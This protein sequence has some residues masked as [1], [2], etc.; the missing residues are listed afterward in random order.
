VNALLEIPKPARTLIVLSA[1]NP[2]LKKSSQNERF[3]LINRRKKIHYLS[4][5]FS[6]IP[7]NHYQQIVQG[8]NYYRGYPVC[9]MQREQVKPFA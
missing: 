8:E 3:F 1:A 4:K 2:V 5:S 6:T 9:S 7:A